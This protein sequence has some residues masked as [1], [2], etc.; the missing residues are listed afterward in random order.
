MK[1]GLGTVQF[2]LD[3][4]ISNRHG[5]C[6]E[7][8]VQRILALAAAQQIRIIDTAAAYGCSEEVLGKNLPPA[9]TF[10]LVTKIAFKAAEKPRVKLAVTASLQRLKQTQL[11]GVLIHQP[12][13]LIAAT[14]DEVWQELQALKHAGLV[15]KIGVSCYTS[16]QIDAI[17]QR[18][19]IDLIQVPVSILDQRL[20]QN[21]QLHALK[22][23]GV[24]IH[25]RS[26]FLQG[27]LLLDVATLS[28]HFNVAKTSLTQFH[29]RCAQLNISPLQAALT[30][31]LNQP[32]I[33]S[34]VV[35]MSSYAEFMQLL[36]IAQTKTTLFDCAAYALTEEKILNP[37]LWQGVL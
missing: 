14:G 16:A 4:G 27:L 6:Q 8:D 20:L 2:G 11:Y 15:Q 24:E 28:E 29:W 25:A 12:E 22:Q 19:A 30:F 36:Q 3:Y 1:L 34:V 10:D 17:M 32:L 21:G 31:V 23:A 9:H 5:R 33:D 37:S 13:Q 18:Y 35:G 26:V 7:Q